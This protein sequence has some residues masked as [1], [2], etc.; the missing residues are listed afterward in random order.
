MIIDK[1]RLLRRCS[2]RI[3][4]RRLSI[5]KRRMIIKVSTKLS[6]INIISQKSEKSA[7]RSAGNEII[8]NFIIRVLILQHTHHKV[9]NT[10]TNHLNASSNAIGSAHSLIPHYHADR[11]P[12]AAS[13]HAIAHTSNDKSRN[14]SVVAEDKIAV[15]GYHHKDTD[16][17][18]DHT[19]AY[20]VDKTAEERYAGNGYK[21]DDTGNHTVLVVERLITA[22]VKGRHVGIVTL[23]KIVD[24]NCHESKDTD[25]VKRANDAKNPVNGRERDDVFPFDLFGFTDCYLNN[26][27]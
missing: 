27:K 22:A 3:R 5:I 8:S 12:E 1:R 25:V 9:R 20:M 23:L 10:N 26:I 4:R 18:E 24:N 15:E 21:I 17:E 2:T 11:G 19:L 6:S 13:D 7:K 14:F 16:G